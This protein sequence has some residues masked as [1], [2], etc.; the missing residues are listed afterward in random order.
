MD[1]S[2]TCVQTELGKGHSYQYVRIVFSGFL[3]P[4][5]PPPVRKFCDVI[6]LLIH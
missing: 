6:H 3:T 1:K 2:F 4:P 5:P